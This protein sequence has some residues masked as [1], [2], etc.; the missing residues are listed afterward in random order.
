MCLGELDDLTAGQYWFGRIL[1]V[2]VCY[3]L[4]AAAL[5]SRQVQESYAN[6]M[7]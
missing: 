6:M 4:H 3:G 2:A 1:V 5:L 7:L